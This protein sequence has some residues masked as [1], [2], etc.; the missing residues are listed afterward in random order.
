[1]AM[2]LLERDDQLAAL[3]G[4]IECA[5]AGRGRTVFVCGEAGIGKTALVTAFARDI[6]DRARMLWGSCEALFTPRPLGPFY[7]VVHAVGGVLAERLEQQAKP[8]DM[9]HALLEAVREHSQPSVVV[10][11]DA[12]W[13][14]HATLDFV[15]FLARRIARLPAILICTY[16]DDEVSAAHPL[17]E[18]LGEIPPDAQQVLKLPALS[19]ATVDRLARESG[20]TDG[21]LYRIT[22]GNPFFVSE[23]IATRGVEVAPTARQAVLARARRLS[24]EARELV[25]LVSVVP[26]RIELALLEG[27][28]RVPLTVLEECAE[29]GLLVFG[30]GHV[31]FKHELARMAIEGALS[32]VKRARLNRLVLDALGELTAGALNA[33]ALTRLAHHALAANDPDAILRFAPQAAR[34][35]AER[36]AQHEAARLLNGALPFADHLPASERPGFLERCARAAFVVGESDDAVALLERAFEHWR[37]VGNEP[38]MAKN[39]LD[40][41]EVIYAGDLHRRGEIESMANEAVGLL[42]SKE[43]G[44]ELAMALLW[45]GVSASKRDP[46]RAK[47]LLNEGLA[48]GKAAAP[49]VA[50][51]EILHRAWHLE[52]VLLAAPSSDRGSQIFDLARANRLDHGVMLGYLHEFARAFREFDLPVMERTV[53]AGMQFAADRQLERFYATRIQQRHQVEIDQHRGRWEAADRQ[54]REFE[55]DASSYWW[56]RSVILRLRLAPMYLRWGRPEGVRW[57]AELLAKE[58]HL[59][60]HEL[61]SLYRALVEQHWLAGEMD[62]AG[63]AAQSLAKVAAFSDHPWVLGEAAFWQW[64]VGGLDGV[65]DGIPEPYT[66]QLAGHFREASLTWQRMGL[67]YETGLALV[68][69]DVAA[70]REALGIFESLQARAAIDLVRSRLHAQGVKAIVQGPRPATRSNSA[71]LTKR[72]ME[73]LQLLA[74][75]LSNTDIARKLRRSV[76]TVESHVAALNGKLGADGRLAAVAIARERGLLSR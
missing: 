75:G 71:Q 62:A 40:R 68:F 33:D 7:D 27:P 56:V 66:L 67:G 72:E 58:A 18:V 30:Q 61:Y 50:M 76:R 49:P 44:P 22:G 42:K 12:H 63:V 60:P 20:R 17:T 2:N 39:L 4:A 9:F 32:P 8:A 31:S 16:R 45:Q 41:C 26:D 73:I 46:I 19:R 57:L 14:D 28:L 15:R 48:I 13:A 51:I 47:A 21:D 43:P 1:M 25:D 5:A 38:A 36:G 23:V 35:A 11:E 69:G 70:Q 3:N 6:D 64:V 54:V 59:V 65:P 37:A 53:A 10:I 52:I 29:R 34:V 24:S 74:A 55:S